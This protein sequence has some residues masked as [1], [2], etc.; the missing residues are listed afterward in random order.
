M[1]QN[2][3][4]TQTTTSNRTHNAKPCKH[5]ID[6]IINRLKHQRDLTAQALTWSHNLP[7]VSDGVG[8]REERPVKPSSPL[9]DKLR[10]SIGHVCLADGTLDIFKNPVEAC[11][12]NKSDV[13]GG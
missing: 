8:G 7:D 10:K 2:E 6:D 13:E 11:M 5:H 4:S 1:I 3:N 12:Y 9:N